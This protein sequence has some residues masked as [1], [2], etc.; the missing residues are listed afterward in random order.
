[1]SVSNDKN[2]I[3]IEDLVNY[4]N[5]RRSSQS[6][7]D[8]TLK[9]L[10]ERK[11]KYKDRQEEIYDRHRN[12]PGQY[13]NKD[14]KELDSIKNTNL[15]ID[16]T[17]EK[18]TK[19]NS[20]F[21]KQDDS[22]NG[23]I[24][25]QEKQLK[26][27]EDLLRQLELIN[28]ETGEFS[29][30]LQDA[31][32]N[33]E[34]S[35]QTLQNQYNAKNDAEWNN[36]PLG[37]RSKLI[38]S[39]LNKYTD[40]MR[41][42]T[43]KRDSILNNKDSS[44]DDKKA[45]ISLFNST[46]QQALAERGNIG[47]TQILQAGADGILGGGIP[48]TED[49]VQTLTATMGPMGIAIQA[50]VKLVQGI[51]KAVGTGI[52]KSMDLQSDY[53]GKIDARLQGSG[54]DENGSGVGI[55][56]KLQDYLGNFAAS[57][58]VNQQKL[59]ENI[60]KLTDQ[61]VAWNIEERALVQTLSERMVT[62]FNALDERLERFI[63]LQGTDLTYAQA[64]IEASLTKFLN[65]NFNDTSFL[66]DLY[67][68]VAGTLLEATSQLNYEE[69]VSFQYAVEKWLG[70]LYAV[71]MSQQGVSTLAQ[72]LT[73][74]ATGN[75]S[76]LSGDSS[77]Q[78]LLAL[79]AKN[80]GLNYTDLLTSG[81]DYDKTNMLMESMV[82]YLQQ[83]VDNTGNNVI[84]SAWSNISTLNM[85]DIRA[86]S[87][88]TAT[89]IKNIS[90]MSAD[91]STGIT[92]FNNQLGKVSNRTSIADMVTNVKDNLVLTL[93]NSLVGDRND[94]GDITTYLL[95]TIGDM[96]PG[97]LGDAIQTLTLSGNLVGSLIT[98]G[99]NKLK[100]WVTGSTYESQGLLGFIESAIR[101]VSDWSGAESTFLK[102]LDV[103]NGNGELI[104]SRGN[105]YL[106]NT[107]GS[108]TKQTSYSSVFTQAITGDTGSI[109]ASEYIGNTSNSDYQQ[110]L[111]EN[112]VTSV[113]ASTITGNQGA[114]RDI[115]D[116][117]AMLFESRT[118]PIRVQLATVEDEAKLILRCD[119][120]HYLATQAEGTGINVDLGNE[121]A[122]LL[123]SKIYNVRGIY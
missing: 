96:L 89:D 59:L 81:L 116:L 86:I 67:D 64:G 5:S 82:N 111:T 44:D 114:V 80:A 29:V 14:K 71:G 109:G 25:K 15:N 42:A 72:G 75:V 99:W 13:S 24:S 43:I 97:V 105:Q 35:K 98:N 51:N 117:Y 58:Y 123:Q 90:E 65:S 32:K 57:P 91:Y 93:G 83:I 104:N 106:V 6:S 53:L 102:Y 9:L 16:K 61:G 79:S 46:K 38:Q 76:K 45:A 41:E 8:V 87:N 74:L 36:V 21:D 110:N 40:T 66:T 7:S 18:L 122:S 56:T 121:D 1:M 119:Y 100:S 101:S 69:A 10:E 70:S 30:E 95:W 68:D 11:Q 39:R 55:Y 94:P 12:K 88:L 19:L 23:I 107:D 103:L 2:F 85:S 20:V 22:L 4:S 54:L 28:Q 63:R 92:E 47:V 3:S 52:S 113:G 112:P 34:S 62:T 108:I 78:T 120:L 27:Q 118:V 73:Y 77:L 115:S 17:I 48:K 31:R 50:L 26:T 84:R 49:L 33:Y 60:S 37:Q